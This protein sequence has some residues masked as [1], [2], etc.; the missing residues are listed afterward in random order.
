MKPSYSNLEAGA[1]QAAT[2]KRLL[3]CVSEQAIEACRHA[4]AIEDLAGV[5]VGVGYQDIAF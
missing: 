1:E 5:D 2:S 4:N 3:R